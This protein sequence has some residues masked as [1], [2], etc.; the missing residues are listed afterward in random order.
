[1][2]KWQYLR[3]LFK[4]LGCVWETHNHQREIW[5]TNQKLPYITAVL[6]KTYP[7]VY[8]FNRHKL[9]KSTKVCKII[10]PKFYEET[11]RLSF[12]CPRNG[13]LHIP[14]QLTCRLFCLWVEVPCKMLLHITNG[15]PCLFCLR[16]PLF[17]LHL[18][19][20]H[21]RVTFLETNYRNALQQV[22][23]KLWF[24]YYLYPLSPL[25][26][27]LVKKL[28]LLSF[29]C[30]FTSDLLGFINILRY[31]AHYHMTVPQSIILNC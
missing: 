1:M 3:K 28:Y 27:V 8:Q 6:P 14:P 20:L 31:T 11:T 10:L 26:Q 13:D 7:A 9:G 16:A 30:C 5:I 2:K 24:I 4:P 19:L 23:R 22:L 15:F 17:T 12:N 21:P 29:I 18:K 25:W